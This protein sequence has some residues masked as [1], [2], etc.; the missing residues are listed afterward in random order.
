MRAQ[1]NR[2]T[3]VIAHRLSTVLGAYRIV[4]LDKGDASSRSARTRNSW[5]GG[6][7]I[8][9]LYRGSLAGGR[10]LETGLASARRDG[11][12][13]LLF[14]SNGHGEDLIAA[15]IATRVRELAP[16][17]EMDGVPGGRVR[18]RLPPS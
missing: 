8:P 13:S 2:T 1:A 9:S 3:F 12:A 4:V 5:S 14:L 15:T 6:A 7:S 16:T 17:V 11:R 18:R 10:R